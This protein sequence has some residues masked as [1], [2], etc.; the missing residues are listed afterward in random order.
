MKPRSIL[1]FVLAFAGWTP[2][3]FAKE[4]SVIRANRLQFAYIE[5]GL[6][7]DPL[8]IC[9]HGFPDDAYTFEDLIE[10]LAAQG[11]HAVAPFTRGYYPSQIPAKADYSV[12]TLAQDA[13]AL[14]EAFGAHDAVIIGHDWGAITGY[15]AANLAP[16]HVSKLVTLAIP[17]PSVLRP[18][19][20]QLRAASQFVQL[21]WGGISERLVAK[22][23]FRYIDDTYAKWS[24]TW[25]GSIV[26]AQTARVKHSFARP[27]RLSAAL[28]YYRSFRKDLTNPKRIGLYRGTTPVPTLTIH[29]SRD[30]ATLRSAFDSTRSGF[31]GPYRLVEIPE[32][33]HFV[34][35]EAPERVWEEI[36]AFIGPAAK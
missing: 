26:E 25:Q 9:L 14:I 24:P 15:A 17:H 28:G 16:E 2:P 1:P 20:E 32:V 11:Y 3:G 36:S 27:G 4:F 29:G 8:V 22:D 18:S 33:G 7:G 10:S 21:P 5:A 31:T 23:G 35:L 12:E 6:K 30:G 19:L 34:H 13:L